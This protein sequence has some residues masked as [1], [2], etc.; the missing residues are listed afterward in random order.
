MRNACGSDGHHLRFA[1]GQ[2]A[3]FIKHQRVEGAG[4]LQ[5]VR[6]PYQYAKFGRAAYAGDN[7]HW[8]R[9]A[10]GARTGDDQH[11]GGDHQGVNN[12]RCRAEEIPDRRAQQGNADHYWN[13]NGGD[14]VSKLANFRLAALGLAHH[15]DNTRQRRVAADGAGGKQHAAVLHHRTRMNGVA[16]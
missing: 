13:K 14:P 10:K 3:G 11:R 12:L 8:G 6:I 1:F 4:P 15:A 5:R 16:V 7:R 9:Q 2:R